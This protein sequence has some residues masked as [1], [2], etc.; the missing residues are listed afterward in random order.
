MHVFR[1]LEKSR[2]HANIHTERNQPADSNPDPLW[3]EVIVLNAAPMC[4]HF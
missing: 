1:L 3:S 4:H 2:E